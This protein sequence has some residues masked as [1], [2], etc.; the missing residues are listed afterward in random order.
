MNG[1]CAPE[2]RACISSLEVF[3]CDVFGS[4]TRILQQRAARLKVT[5]PML[6]QLN[7]AIAGHRRRAVDARLLSLPQDC[8]RDRRVASRRRRA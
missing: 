7:F 2:T 5:L 8:A 4:Q 3:H 6:L 1:G